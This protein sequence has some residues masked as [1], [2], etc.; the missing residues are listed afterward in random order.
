M[1]ITSNILYYFCHNNALLALHLIIK[2]EFIKKFQTSA[3]EK[4]WNVGKFYLKS[5]WPD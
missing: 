5:S 3:K 1:Q 2:A 4:F